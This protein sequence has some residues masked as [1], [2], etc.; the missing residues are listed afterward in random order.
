MKKVHITSGSDSLR[1][2]R[3][4]AQKSSSILARNTIII[5]I[6]HR[7]EMLDLIQS[8]S[9]LEFS[10]VWSLISQSLTQPVS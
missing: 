1:D 9:C 3:Q 10:S 5:I 2:V 7:H 6:H 8:I 4:C